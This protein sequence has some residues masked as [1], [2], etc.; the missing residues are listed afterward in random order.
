MG[1]QKTKQ[2]A[3]CEIFLA[4]PHHFCGVADSQAL[5]P[6]TVERV[7]INNFETIPHRQRQ[8][9][10]NM[11]NSSKLPVIAFFRRV[12]SNYFVLNSN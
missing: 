6:R 1:L 10:V 7:V 2:F 3:A 12:F 8:V 9:L 4:K 11:L 5:F